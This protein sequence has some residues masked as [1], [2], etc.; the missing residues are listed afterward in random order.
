MKYNTN[1]GNEINEILIVISR[2]FL[3][4]CIALFAFLLF[5]GILGIIFFVT[6]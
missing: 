1:N 5:K 3:Y 2:F 6:N 4:F